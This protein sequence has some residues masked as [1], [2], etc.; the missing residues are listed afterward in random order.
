MLFL[1]F[2]I[3]GDRFALGIDELIEILPLMALKRLR[4]APPGVAGSF[5]YRGRF[6]P[7]VDPALIETGEP[8]RELMSTR[9]VMT[10]YRGGLLGLIAEQA[11]A[12]FRCE[13]ADFTPFAS[14]PDGL[15]QRIEVDAL[16]SPAIRNYLS[17]EMADGD[18]LR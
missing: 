4:Q 14:G 18:D 16:L 10:R 17:H 3:G 6:V 8:A 11:T 1:L 15:V 5:D 9:I 13:P 12:T 7:V 2:R